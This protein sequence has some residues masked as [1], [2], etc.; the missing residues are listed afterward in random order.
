MCHH[1]FTLMVKRNAIPAIIYIL[2]LGFGIWHIMTSLKQSKNV[3]SPNGR[4]TEKEWETEIC[5]MRT[6]QFV[7]PFAFRDNVVIVLSE[8]ES[9][10]G[11]IDWFHDSG[12]SAV[13]EPIKWWQGTD[14]E[15]LNVCAW[16]ELDTFCRMGLC[17]F[18]A[19]LALCSV[20]CILFKRNDILIERLGNFHWFA[21]VLFLWNMI[22]DFRGAYIGWE[23]CYTV[24]LPQLVARQSTHILFTHSFSY[25]SIL[26]VPEQ[27]MLWNVDQLDVGECSMRPF[28][29]ILIGNLSVW[30]LQV[31]GTIIPVFMKMKVDKPPEISGAEMW[32]ADRELYGGRATQA[33]ARW[34]S[35]RTES[36]RTWME[37]PK[38]KKKHKYRVYHHPVDR[39]IGRRP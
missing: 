7:H 31:I 2:I 32:E 36:V 18:L 4:W 3:T 25:F 8:T 38:K 14:V 17:G 28:A 39:N 35:I 10:S 34:S 6:N 37:K 22:L 24:C 11:I 1:V 29:P 5:E 27:A 21:S 19:F 9:R 13:R 12:S 30:L 33:L 15:A 20:I 16:K 26:C 23:A